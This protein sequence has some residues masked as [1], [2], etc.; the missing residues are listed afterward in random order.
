MKLCLFF[1][2]VIIGLPNGKCTVYWLSQALMTISD[3]GAGV[4]REVYEV[5]SSG[6]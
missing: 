1:V 3:S 2:F 5:I 6:V 4:Y